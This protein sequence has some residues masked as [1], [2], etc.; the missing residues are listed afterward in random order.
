MSKQ[1]IDRRSFVKGAGLTGA[2]V[3]AASAMP[4][5]ADEPAA[6]APAPAEDWREAP[7]P[8]DESA[9]V[10]ELEA[11]YVVVGMGHAGTACARVLAEAGESV[12]CLESQEQ[13]YY[14]VF[15]EDFGHINSAYLAERGV[16]PV[17]TIEFFNNWMLNAQNACNP[18]LVMQYAKYSGEAFDNFIAPLSDE[19]MATVTLDY[20]PRSSATV[21]EIA[22]QKFWNGT[23]QF[24]V[25]GHE[26]TQIL[27]A[28]H[29]IIVE[30]GGQIVWG[31]YAEQL[32]MDGERVAGVVASTADG[33]IRVRAAEAV[34]LAAGDFSGNEAMRNDLL[35]TSVDIADEDTMWMG[36]GRDG[37]GIRMG[38][39]AGGRLEP[40]P[41]PSMGGDTSHPRAP[42]NPM[43]GLWLNGRG[44]RFC[45]EFFGDPIW[46]GR[47]VANQKFDCIYTV[48]DG[49]LMDQIAYNIPAHDRFDPTDP[50]E[51]AALQDVLDAAV[52]A[53]AE[54]VA[55]GNMAN[56]YTLYAADDLE[57]LADYAGMAPEVKEAFLASVAHY[58][59]LAA[60]GADTDYGK[61]PSVLWALDTAPYYLS[62]GRVGMIGFMLV[63]VGGLMT[64]KNQQV[65]NQA[66][67]PIEG[68]Y[69]TGNC[70]GRRFGSA[71]FSPTAGVSVGMAETLG[72]VLGKKLC[73]E[74]Y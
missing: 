58:N 44:E 62:V 7:A 46:T 12:I 15:G 9:I 71:Y 24:I 69:A 39:W 2:A 65:L 47:Q 70:C 11:D 57:T 18:D 32:V 37:R 33:Y 74:Q 4:A 16:D 25:E 30:N 61:D 6:P 8:I 31:A 72:Y 53:G 59:E 34:V 28:H 14:M 3:A 13:E 21:S 43:T 19:F 54:G 48:H 66:K 50:E 5:L 49:K 51:V 73:G 41:L 42:M 38:M 60:A 56:G 67:D 52:A 27:Q 64:D 55:G 35:V 10:E 17:D 20:W 63:T 22:G 68:L 23:P 29:Q 26:F 1:T 40:R 36:A 45:N